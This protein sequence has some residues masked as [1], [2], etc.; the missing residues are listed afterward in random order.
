MIFNLL[1]HVSRKRRIQFMM[2]VM[3]TVIGAFAEIFSLGAIVPFVAILTQP[4]K[5]FSYPLI[6]NFATYLSVQNTNELIVPM[7]WLFIT[8]ATF[9]GASR[10]II[11]YISIRLGN[12]IGADLSVEMYRRTLYQPYSAHITRSSSELIS[13][14]TQK[15]ATTTGILTSLVS[16]ITSSIIF[17]MIFLAL[18]TIY[19]E[20]AAL[21]FGSFGAVYIL[22]TIISKRRLRTNSDIVSTQQT[23]VVKVLQEGLGAI[24]DILLDRTQPLYVSIFNGR[25]QALQRATG[26]NL[27]I[28]LAPR[29]IME[30]LALILIGLFSIIV[31]NHGGLSLALP[32]LAAFALGVQRLLP[33]LQQLYANAAFIKGSQ[34]SLRDVL[35]ILNQPIQGY[36]ANHSG[37]NINF[38]KQIEFKNIYFSYTPQGPIVFNNLNLCI[39]R[40]SIVG[41]AGVTGSG[42]STI[43]DLLMCLLLPTSGKILIDDEPLT[44][45]TIGAWQKLISH[46]PQN[47]YLTDESILKNIAF[48][49]PLSQIN[50]EKVK[51]A[52]RKAQLY[53][54][55][56]NLTDGFNTIVGERGVRLSG[57]QRQRIGIARALYKDSSVLIF[58]EATSALDIETENSVMESIVRLGDELTIILVAHRINTLN[59]CD[60]IIEISKLGCVTQWT[61]KDYC[62][63]LNNH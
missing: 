48:G 51:Y 7:A 29:Y 31:G 24:R 22:I 23:Y 58:D 5:I 21:T 18:I 49:V 32:V 15:V 52:A 57:G 8:A 36:I 28:T 55:V 42:K 43:T 41:I 4:E 61:Y 33:L 63:K 20:I 17:S 30:A 3:L 53:D 38:S 10:V 27:F 26:E 9:A 54:F 59:R 13:G 19:P 14:I 62:A 40:G 34:S 60:Q 11:L 44:F 47:I 25:I 16:I 1:K 45:D 46:V 2:L 37:Q 6:S 56:S 50:V 39:K 12:S 35:M